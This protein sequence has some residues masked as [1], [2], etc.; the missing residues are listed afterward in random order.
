MKNEDLLLK[1][2]AASAPLRRREATRYRKTGALA[3]ERSTATARVVGFSAPVA[4]RAAATVSRHDDAPALGAPLVPAVTL[5]PLPALAPAPPA[6]PAPPV[7]LVPPPVIAGSTAFA[8]GATFPGCA[9]FARISAGAGPA[10][11]AAA[12]TA[13]SRACARSR[14][15]AAGPHL[16]RRLPH[17]RRPVPALAPPAPA[18]HPPAPRLPTGTRAARPTAGTGA[19]LPLHSF[20]RRPFR[21]NPR[22]PPC[23]R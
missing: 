7:P 6:P 17:S 19:P 18:L 5:P 9:R 4:R 10:A 1:P 3:P 23:P 12:R 15:C 16:R 13:R 8:T 2:D 21:P 20:D 11:P 22:S 14:T